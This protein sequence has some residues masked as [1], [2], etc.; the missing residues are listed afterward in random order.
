MTDFYKLTGE[1]GEAIHGGSGT[2]PLPTADGPGDWLT[3]A[4]PLVP[5]ENGLHVLRREHVLFEWIGPV[6]WRVEV[7]AAGLIEDATKCVVARARLIE[8]VEPWNPVTLRLF[9][10]DCAERALWRER[11]AGREPDPRSWEA[12]RV[13][14]EA[15]HGRAQAAAAGAARDAAWAAAASAWAADAADAAEAAQ[16]TAG[17]ADA[18]EAARDAAWA[19][20]A[21]ARD[22]ERTWQ[23]DRLW[24]YLDGRTPAPVTSNDEKARTP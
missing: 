17:A 5:C 23:R 3:A 13:A 16:A 21:A 15:T 6:L 11:A 22:A 18:A 9:A 20:G 1:Q 2:W 10:A 19:A 4:G 7:D 8:R 12:V 24:T 14:R